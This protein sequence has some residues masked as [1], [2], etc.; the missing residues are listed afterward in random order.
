MV[1]KTKHSVESIEE[2][3]VSI[4]QACEIFEHI[5]RDINNT[6]DLIKSILREIQ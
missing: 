4:N 5:Y 2:N 3:S 6:K 1:N